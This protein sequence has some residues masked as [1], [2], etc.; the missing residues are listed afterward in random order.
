MEE[1]EILPRDGYLHTVHITRVPCSI[2]WWFSTKRKNID[3]GL[4]RRPSPPAAGSDDAPAGSAST[5]GSR[6]STMNTLSGKRAVVSPGISQNQSDIELRVSTPNQTQQ[7]QQQQQQQRNAHFKLQDKGIVELMPL[8]HYESSKATIKGSWTAVDPGVYI[9]YFDNSFSKNTSKRLSFCVAVRETKGEVASA[10]SK[11][12]ALI[13]GWLLKKKRKRMQ[14]WANRWFTIQGHWLLYSTTE[15]GIPRAKV[16]LVN[17]VVSMSKEDCFIT[18]DGDEGFFQL[19]AQKPQDFTAWVAALKKTKEDATAAAANAH[20]TDGATFTLGTVPHSPTA[21]GVLPLWPTHST[22]ASPE[23]A[24]LAHARFVDSTDRLNALI[25]NLQVSSGSDAIQAALGYIQTIKDSEDAIYRLVGLP[26]KPG[27]PSISRWETAASDAPSLALSTSR[28]SWFSGSGSD[29]FYDTNDVLEVAHDEGEHL[30]PRVSTDLHPGARPG[31]NV[32][33]GDSS[34]RS[35]PSIDTSQPG[36]SVGASMQIGDACSTSDSDAAADGFFDDAPDI[37]D[38]RQLARMRQDLIRDPDFLAAMAR[39]SIQ[40][41]H[42]VDAEPKPDRGSDTKPVTHKDLDNSPLV[43]LESMRPKFDN[44][45]PRTS[46]PAESSE[47]NVSLIS[48]LRKNVGKDLTSIA[49]PLVMNEP[50]NALQGLC[51]ELMYNRLLQKADEMSDSLDRLM[52]VAAFAISTLSSKKYR[53]ERKP[54]NPLLGETYEMVDPRSGYRFVSE[55]VSH[56]P[57]VMVC[58]ADSP[59]Y[60]FWQDSSGKSKFWGKSMEFIQTSNVHIELLKHHDHFTYCKP[61]VLVRGLIT[62][63]RTV[64][65]A[66]EMTIT[67]RS[68]GD[69]CVVNFKEAGMFSA[70]NDMVECLLY[71]GSTGDDK[72]QRVLRGSWSSHLRFEKSPT[73]AETLWTAVSLPPESESYYR[74]SYFTMRLNE[75]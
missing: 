49:M 34:I 13:S 43:T 32:T 53:A 1:I 73:Q 65:F 42:A 51:E 62:G 29:L 26:E 25:S 15:G 31:V 58:Y 9:L 6:T 28:A 64:D 46:L 63:N 38:D 18:I 27:R 60:R 12:R 69:R 70:S 8:K 39:N 75:L 2:Q 17:A 68:T 55:K 52:Y 37:G 7:Q 4:F 36:V 74:F 66:G 71:R 54:F 47:V 30:I 40:H 24:T 14:G 33:S 21:P 35:S 11:P 56:H 20:Y 72:V 23:D 10:S 50:I 22:S 41:P 48:I 16:D 67:N 3:F 59:S 45:E 19:H 61:S 5:T 44:Y 57:P